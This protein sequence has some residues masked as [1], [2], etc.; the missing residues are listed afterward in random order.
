MDI[1]VNRPRDVYYCVNIF[2]FVFKFLNTGLRV[3]NYELTSV[4]LSCNFLLKESLTNIT[5]KYRVY[6]KDCI[7]FP[8]TIIL[9]LVMGGNN[10][11]KSTIFFKHPI[12]SISLDCHWPQNIC[13]WE[14]IIFVHT[15]T[16]LCD[17]QQP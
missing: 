7:I 17:G 15:C 5:S 6:E 1:I 9:S 4:F 11:W 14:K 2:F 3:E 8:K 10:L 16:I 13:R 12:Y